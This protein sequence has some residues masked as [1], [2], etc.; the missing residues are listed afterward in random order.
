MGSW[1]SAKAVFSQFSFAASEW[2]ALFGSVPK[3]D[4]ERYNSF[5][6]VKRIIPWDEQG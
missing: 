4:F 3:E 2:Q 1:P 6:D 5:H